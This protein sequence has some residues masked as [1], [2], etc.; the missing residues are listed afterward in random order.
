LLLRAKQAAAT[1]T[2]SPLTAKDIPARQDQLLAEF[3]AWRKEYDQWLKTEGRNHNG[4][5]ELIETK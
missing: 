5:N 1:A 4:L 2:A 3:V